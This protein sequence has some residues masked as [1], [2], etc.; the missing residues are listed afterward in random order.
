M[1]AR[2]QRVDSTEPKT[3]DVDESSG[4]RRPGGVTLDLRTAGMSLHLRMG[5]A[6]VRRIGVAVG[7]GSGERRT[8]DVAQ[9][10]SVVTS[11]RRVVE[12]RRGRQRQQRERG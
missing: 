6:A 4:G 1:P 11:F 12:M 9:N 7:A 10:A 8:V 5:T 3:A 2:Q